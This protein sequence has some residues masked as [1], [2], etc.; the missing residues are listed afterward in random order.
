MLYLTLRKPDFEN[1]FDKQPHPG[2]IKRSRLI[3]RAGPIFTAHL[4]TA[5]MNGILAA[6]VITSQSCE[7]PA[8]PLSF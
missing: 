7:I 6:A 8:E 4:V 1:R 2:A 3:H 5:I